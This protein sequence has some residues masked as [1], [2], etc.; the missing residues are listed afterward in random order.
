MTPLNVTDEAL[1]N[2]K[3]M[4]AQL[5][6]CTHTLEITQYIQDVYDL[7][8]KLHSMRSGDHTL[9]I[10]KDLKDLYTEYTITTFGCLEPTPD[11]LVQLNRRIE[12][13]IDLLYETITLCTNKHTI[14]T[15]KEDLEISM[16]STPYHHK[17]QL[18]SKVY[19]TL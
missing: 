3:L 2:T 17:L 4:W 12:S 1:L 13:D 7:T 6:I 16:P 11:I 19:H 18:R 10:Q 5:L 8:I 14:C 15:K 9:L